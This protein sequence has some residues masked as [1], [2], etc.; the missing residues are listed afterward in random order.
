MAGARLVGNK[1]GHLLDVI[2]IV[3]PILLCNV[4]RAT[5]IYSTGVC[6]LARSSFFTA[7]IEE[8]P[9][10]RQEADSLKF[11]CSQSEGLET[12][13]S[14]AA[15]I[16]ISPPQLKPATAIRLV[17]IATIIGTAFALV[18][19]QIQSIAATSFARGAAPGAGIP[20]AGL[21]PSG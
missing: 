11:R 8:S 21:I 12:R 10:L 5:Q 13:G 2:E 16:A 3:E 19:R 14:I 4:L 17:S 6:S 9:P 7:V 18:F 1:H 20:P 15:L